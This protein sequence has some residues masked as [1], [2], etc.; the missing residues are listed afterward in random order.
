MT[1]TYHK[2]LDAYIQFSILYLKQPMHNT[3]TEVTKTI[4][5]L[6][7]VQGTKKRL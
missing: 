5:Y 4:N 3:G 6:Q 7:Y 2:N 1:L